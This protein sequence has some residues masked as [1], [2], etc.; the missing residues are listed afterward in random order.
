MKVEV[1]KTA[2]AVHYI[3]EA[4]SRLEQYWTNPNAT[5]SE[6]EYKVDM[7]NYL[8]FV[9]QYQ[10]KHA[11]IDTRLFGFTITPEVQEWVDKVIAV[12]ANKI[13][14]K[15]AFLLP[16]DIFEQ[17]SIQQTMEEQNGQVYGGVAYFETIEE[18]IKW[19]KSK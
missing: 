11:L 2:F 4:E 3:D 7:F 12:K 5:M 13:V 17:V 18:A 6:E 9:E 19:L 15:I 16:S 1:A 10:I 14:Q 8:K